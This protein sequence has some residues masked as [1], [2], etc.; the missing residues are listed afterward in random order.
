MY[1]YPRS[2]SLTLT[3]THNCS[4]RL[5]HT[6]PLISAHMY[7][8]TLTHT[9][10]SPL[11]YSPIRT[12]AHYMLSYTNPYTY[13]P[14]YTCVSHTD[15]L[16]LIP[17]HTQS[18]KHSNLLTCTF[19]HTH[20]YSHTCSPSFTHSQSHILIHIHTLTDTP[21]HTHRHKLPSHI[22]HTNHTHFP[23]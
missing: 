9:H 18:H 22:Q 4:H 2:H 21:T 1:T 16:T 14:I 20:T 19:S 15:S 13:L 7:I 8:P 11:T 3:Y 12:P 5:F 17:A 23:S 6:L 10:T